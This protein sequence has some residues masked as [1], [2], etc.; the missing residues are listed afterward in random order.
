MNR[1]IFLVGAPASGKTTL[2]R[3]LLGP[4]TQ[5]VPSPKWTIGRDARLAAGHYTGA[6]FDGA[7][8]VP[9]NG[10]A[11]AL[12]WWE[13]YLSG[14]MFGTHSLTLF[15]GDRFSHAG[16]LFSVRQAPGADAGVVLVSASDEELDRRRAERAAAGS[17]QNAAWMR[18]RETK[19]IR[20]TNEFPPERRLVYPG[21]GAS[22]VRDWMESW[23]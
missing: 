1:A 20:F 19:A 11:A 12:D 18:G 15:D 2:A 14:F 17:V 3:A 16:A 22:V 23:S 7:D 21:G 10:V 13:S 5:L 8:R 9:Y 4:V 6:T